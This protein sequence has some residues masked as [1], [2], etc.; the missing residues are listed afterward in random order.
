MPTSSAPLLNAQLVGRGFQDANPALHLPQLIQISPNTVLFRFIY[1]DMDRHTI[2]GADGPWWMEA[3]SFKRLVHSSLSHG[4]LL[5]GV[6]G[7]LAGVRTEWN[8]VNGYV[9]AEVIRPLKCWK[10]KGKQL[11]DTTKRRVRT[12]STPV[13]V[14]QD[15]YQLYIP[16]IGG[17]SSLFSASLRYLIFTSIQS[18]QP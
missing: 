14:L 4:L 7:R 10:G 2:T 11:P 13:P 6:A 15:L 16:G 12:R 8:E 17:K 9:Q 5:S 1:A 18:A 3:D